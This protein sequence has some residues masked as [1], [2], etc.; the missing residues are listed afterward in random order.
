MTSPQFCYD[1]Q[2]ITRWA[3]LQIKIV[4]LE[5]WTNEFEVQCDTLDHL[6]RT[7]LPVPDLLKIDVEGAGRRGAGGRGQ[8]AAHPASG[9]LHGGAC[10]QHLRARVGGAATLET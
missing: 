9:D 5:N 1:T 3:P 4:K 8:P 6:H 10:L 2:G 7:G